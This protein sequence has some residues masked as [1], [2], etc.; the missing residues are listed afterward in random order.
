M[1]LRQMYQNADQHEQVN[2]E[3]AHLKAEGQREINRIKQEGNPALPIL[4][5]Q[6]AQS[7]PSYPPAALIYTAP[8]SHDPS[9]AHPSAS[10]NQ[11]SDEITKGFGDMDKGLISLFK[12]IKKLAKDIITSRS[13]SRSRYRFRSETAGS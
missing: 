9:I 5:S 7:F 13:Q 10:I 3:L 8:S 2:A 12:N 1:C 4:P 11:M 6:S